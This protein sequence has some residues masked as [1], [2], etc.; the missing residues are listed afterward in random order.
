MGIVS[1]LN[2]A[3]NTSQM[4][5][6]MKADREAHIT[7]AQ[8]RSENGKFAG[9]QSPRSSA[10][11]RAFAAAHQGMANDHQREAGLHDQHAAT[12]S[13]A[14]H[15]KAYEAHKAAADAHRVAADKHTAVASHYGNDD[16]KAAAAAKTA[17]DLSKAATSLAAKANAASFQASKKEK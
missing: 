8:E 15:S 6:V 16:P 11:N 14:G 4:V 1:V 17:M 7:K 9:G 3:L 5:D 12:E 13:H 2:S 10:A